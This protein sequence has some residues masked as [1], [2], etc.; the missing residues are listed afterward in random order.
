[1]FPLVLSDET[2]SEKSSVVRY[3]P[4]TFFNSVSAA[5]AFVADTENTPT[6]I[7]RLPKTDNIRFFNLFSPKLSPLINK[8][9][10]CQ[11]LTLF[12]KK[13]KFSIIFSNSFFPLHLSFDIE[14]LYTQILQYIFFFKMI[15]FIFFYIN[16]H[17]I[18]FYLKFI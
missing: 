4:S 1:M 17:T 9:L 11:K 16:S 3:E 14:H 13:T 12:Y 18:I 5:S 6:K 8:Q 7:A 2:P 15:Y 10:N